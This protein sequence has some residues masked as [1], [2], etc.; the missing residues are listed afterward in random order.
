M[1]VL[2]ILAQPSPPESSPL[3]GV[4]DPAL[5]ALQRMRASY[6]WVGMWAGRWMWFYVVLWIA[7]L[8]A[9]WR[10]RGDFTR[11]T[12]LFL[13][14]LPA[15]GIVSVPLSYLLLE[16]TKWVLMPQ[17]QPGRYLLF[18]TLF[19]MMLGCVAAVRAAERR[20]YFETFVFFVVPLM[21]TGAEWD[22][23][24]LNS[25]PSGANLRIG[26]AGYGCGDSAIADMASGAR[27]IDAVLC[28]SGDWRYTE[29]PRYSFRRTR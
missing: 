3:L 15:I 11:E 27:R 2:T 19:A 5:E 12:S 1:I 7:G 4:I 10:V 17:F 9:W 6:N 26:S 21:A 28:L 29:L 25:S 24:K 23:E 22:T 13:L 14:S 16:H 8:A 18:V 20:R